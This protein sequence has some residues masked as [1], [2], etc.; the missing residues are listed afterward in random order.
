[1]T[2]ILSICEPKNTHIF[3]NIRICINPI[4]IALFI[5]WMIRWC[6]RQEQLIN[7]RSIYKQMW[8]KQKKISKTNEK[9]YGLVAVTLILSLLFDAVLGPPADTLGREPPRKEPK[10]WLIRSVCL[11]KPRSGVVGST[12]KQFPAKRRHKILHAMIRLGYV[13]NG[14]GSVVVSLE[15]TGVI[16][17]NVVEAF[18]RFV[19]T[20][21]SQY[22]QI[23][24]GTV[25][26]CCKAL[27]ICGYVYI[28]RVYIH[29]IVNECVLFTSYVVNSGRV[30]S[31][32]ALEYIP[33]RWHRRLPSW[34][35]RTWPSPRPAS[36]CAG[37][38]SH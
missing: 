29:G 2:A 32:S 31:G 8:K 17:S 23:C 33:W 16:V 12:W 14:V 1:M 18:T 27:F 30:T 9:G 28:T 5:K 20:L 11:F 6:V 24:A 38:F 21:E 34:S 10:V 4:L 15:R 36:G 22:L 26:I 3:S 37:R 35:V 19:T 25:W 13:R 7:K